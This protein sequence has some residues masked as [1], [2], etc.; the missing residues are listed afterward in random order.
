MLS[1]SPDPAAFP[2]RPI[3][4]GTPHPGVF[5]D[6][7][8]PVHSPPPVRPSRPIA[9][10]LT[11]LFLALALLV[12][13]HLRAQGATGAIEGRVQNVATGAY[14]P[15]ARVALKGTDR[16][17]L[18][19]EFGRYRFGNVPS[20]TATLSV[21]YTG[22]DAQESAVDVGPG[23]TVQQDFELTSAA[24]YGES[25]AAEGR[26]V[27]L[28][29]FVVN[30]DREL[31]A[32]A[33][34][35]NEQR[36]AAEVKNV[37]STDA[38]GEIVASNVGDFLKF[39]PGV[40][41]NYGS[42]EI[43][44]F[45][46]RGFNSNLV[47]VTIDGATVAN[48]GG[49]RSFSLDATAINNISR[50]E[51][52]K[53]NI[54]SR[55]ATGLGGGVNLIPKTSLDRRK[56][57]FEYMAALHANSN[58]F[59]LGETGGPEGR[60][61]HKARPTWSFNYINPVSPTFGFTLNAASS[62]A[63]TTQFR[64]PLT[65]NFNAG[66]G[67][68]P[69]N[70]FLRRVHLIDGPRLDRRQSLG[71]G[72]DWKPLPNLLV[73]S[74]VRYARIDTPD[75]QAKIFLNT[76]NRPLSYGPDFVNGRNGAGTVQQMP[77]WPHRHRDAIDLSTRVDYSVGD[78]RL[79]L[80][81]SLSAA[82]QD[83][84]DEKQG[85]FESADARIVSPTVRFAGVNAQGAPDQMLAFNNT[86]TTALDWT[87]LAGYRLLTAQFNPR[88]TDED[89]REVRFSARRAFTWGAIEA[90]GL[91]QLQ[92]RDFLR[93][94]RFYDF[95]GPDGAPNTADDFAG[96]YDLVEPYYRTDPAK[97]HGVPDYEHLSLAKLYQLYQ[98]NPAYFRRRDASDIQNRAQNDEYFEERIDAVYL[99][100]ERRFFG[101]RLNVLG[102][103]RWERTTDRGLGML[104]NQDATDPDPIEAA[105]KRYIARGLSARRSY[106]GIYPS[107]NT[108]LLLTE[109]LQLRAGY[110]RTM[111]RPNLGEV[112]PRASFNENENPVDGGA[113]G[114]VNIRNSGLVPW[115]ADGFDLRLEY[116]F[117]KTGTAS[118]GLY[119]RDVEN[120]F[121]NENQIADEGL[122]AQHG[123]GPEYLGWEIR[124]KRNGGT[125]R[126][127][128]LEVDY[129]Q[130]LDGLLPDWARGFTV[131]ANGALLD[132]DGENQS[133]FGRFQPKSAN[134][135]FRYAR[136][137][138]GMNF[139]WN[140]FGEKLFSLRT[141]T[142]ATGQ[143]FPAEQYEVARITIDADV[144]YQVTRH[145][146]AYLAVKNLQN[147]YHELR[148]KGEG[149]GAHPNENTQN[150]GAGWQFGIRGSF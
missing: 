124:T 98:S 42:S 43:T 129:R 93:E 111:G 74:S 35:I 58:A 71:G 101:N 16:V 133:H 84:T 81:A 29:P 135:G 65:I 7:A 1:G 61:A 113:L 56:P 122:L 107:F 137:K 143:Q 123:L 82:K 12:S 52:Y 5:P 95:V 130:N 14:L 67:A 99:Q 59:T 54:P 8:N 73:S 127:S 53:T 23:L 128:G 91:T 49:G 70:P 120:F 69:Q 149:I 63:F 85:N 28:D 27:V 30:A 3:D 78:W 89:R 46:V 32:A 62:D 9:P 60:K 125:A 2:A 97:A 4:P 150:Y 112:I 37:V 141:F 144:S 18:T 106:D 103:A 80:S 50:I 47:P 38:F 87:K 76:G 119:R 57:V 115:E 86:G 134:W 72:L 24:R 17:A 117:R 55:P 40:T 118:I 104:E 19:D 139:R 77:S 36:F 132:L 44:E 90:G 34:A 11:L 51:V 33:L 131:F 39:L 146:T 136:S 79:N 147:D 108:T 94:R 45:Q 142:D 109:N 88:I 68:S 10:G 92:Q 126:I 41:V 13:P 6:P 21:F 26:A 114:V 96:N 75:T 83:E 25:T 48:S 148:F 31:D 140:Y 20:G 66:D 105:R 138:L 110:A 22:L 102:G 121:L 116:Y 100:A 15:N 145:V 64:L